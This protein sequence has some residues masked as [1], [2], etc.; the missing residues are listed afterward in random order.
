MTIT[1]CSVTSGC[2]M[3]HLC[4]MFLADNW[5]WMVLPVAVCG[6]LA[7]FIDVRFII[8]AL[9][10][11]FVILPML[12]AL[13]YFYYGLSPEARWSIMEKTATIDDSG[14]TLVFADERMK[15]HVIPWDDVRSI[16]EKDD[17][18]IIMLRGKRYTCLMLPASAVD[19]DV[20]QVLRQLVT[21]TH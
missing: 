20:T 7:I 10:I 5:L 19:P 4:S 3:R 8:V 9:M 17:A 14:I 2:Y 11:L 21:Q 6:M 18:L 16:I 13:L 12:L 1:N 15:K